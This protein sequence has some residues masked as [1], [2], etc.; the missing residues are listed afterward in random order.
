MHCSENQSSVINVHAIEFSH[1][2]LAAPGKDGEA[3]GKVVK[4]VI[5]CF[6]LFLP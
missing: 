2:P 4:M 1:V 3:A 6:T 5:N